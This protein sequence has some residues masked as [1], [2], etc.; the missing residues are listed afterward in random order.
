MLDGDVYVIDDEGHWVK[1]E[2]KRV[3]C[4]ANYPFGVKYSLTLH[5]AANRRILG[6]DNAHAVRI[7]TKPGAKK[8]MVKDHKHWYTTVKPYPY[9]SA[10]QLIE[11]FW[12]AVD[13]IQKGRNRK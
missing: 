10:V 11:D 2:V 6:F 8:S 9:T 1:F 12:G 5:D 4:D 13:Q 7:S 3:A